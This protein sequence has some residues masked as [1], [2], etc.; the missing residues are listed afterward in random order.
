VRGRTATAALV[1][2]DNAVTLRV[3]KTPVVRLATGS[4]PTVNEQHRDPRGVTTLLHME[5]VG[6]LNRQ[7]VLHIRVGIGIENMHGKLC[8]APSL[9][10]LKNSNSSLPVIALKR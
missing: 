6:R 3:K 10:L 9:W 5:H 4:W 7:G 2:E 1:E 8:S